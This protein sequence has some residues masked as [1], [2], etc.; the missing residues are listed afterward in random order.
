MIAIG[1]TWKLKH[2]RSA[3]PVLEISQGGTTVELSISKQKAY[4]IM[5]NMD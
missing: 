1:E 3:G 4:K 5:R 2:K